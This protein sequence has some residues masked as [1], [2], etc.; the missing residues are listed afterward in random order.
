MDKKS[1]MD[2]GGN[3]TVSETERD[4]VGEFVTWR[5][6]TARIFFYLFGGLF[7]NPHFGLWFIFVLILLNL[8]TLR[9]RFSKKQRQFDFI[10]GDIEFFDKLVDASPERRGASPPT[11]G[12]VACHL[13]QMSSLFSSNHF[14]RRLACLDLWMLPNQFNFIYLFFSPNF[15]HE[16]H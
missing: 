2:G 4:E 14:P 8:K 11:I 6:G 3:P 16:F 1:V 5:I 13:L 7:Y 12:Y 15:H 9:V 10:E